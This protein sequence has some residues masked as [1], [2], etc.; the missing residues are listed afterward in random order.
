MTT[1]S[2]TKQDVLAEIKLLYDSKATKGRIVDAISNLKL[3]VT[4]TGDSVPQGYGSLEELETSLIAEYNQVR[5]LITRYRDLKTALQCSNVANQSSVSD[6][7]SIMI[8]STRYKLVTAMEIRH[9]SIYLD[10]MLLTRMASAYHG[11]KRSVANMEEVYK[12][13]K[14][15]YLAGLTTRN[16]QSEEAPMDATFM[17]QLG[18]QYDKLNKPKLIDPLKLESKMKELQ[19]WIDLVKTQVDSAISVHNCTTY[20]EV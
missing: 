13:N 7:V 18:Q 2:K 4:T 5:D 12:R 6:Y 10:E 9:C 1:V 16:K 17:E 3:I 15:T 20:I 11:N 19:E 8:G 14:E